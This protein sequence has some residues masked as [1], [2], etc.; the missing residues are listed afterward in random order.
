MSH[1]PYDAN[2]LQAELAQL[3]AA[4]RSVEAPALDEAILRARFR[5]ARLREP[6][7]RDTGNKRSRNA[8]RA[9]GLRR[10]PLAAAAA[11]V[12][13][14]GG[15]L[16]VVALR[17]ERAGPVPVAVE[18]AGVQ[19][20][21]VGAFQPLQSSPGLSASASYS[22]VRVRIPLSAFAAVPGTVQGGT[23]EA[24]L[25]VGEDGLARAIRF[26]EADASLVSVADQ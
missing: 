16:A 8:E 2:G 22:V 23:I 14:V 1:L 9:G 18:T 6:G 5:D 21:A 7:L 4:L 26:N 3:R 25:L 19:P 15:L 20:A 17:S 24:D 11:V 10:L 12:L 13:A